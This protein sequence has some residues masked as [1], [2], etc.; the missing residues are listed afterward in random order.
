MILKIGNAIPLNNAISNETYRIHHHSHMGK[1]GSHQ[2][3]ESKGELHDR[4][5]KTLDL[6]K[7]ADLE[8][9]RE[10][11]LCV[12]PVMNNLRTILGL[13]KKNIFKALI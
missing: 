12:I 13:R 5:Q 11:S 7:K 2:S 3:D 9:K 1:D 6:E 8:K 10:N 4:Y